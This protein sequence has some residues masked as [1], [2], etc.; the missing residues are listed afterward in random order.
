MVGMTFGR[1]FGGWFVTKGRKL[2]LYTS[3]VI[4]LL[5]IGIMMV[6]DIR[7]FIVGRFIMGL[8]VGIFNSVGVRFVEEC[9]PP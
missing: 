1:L 7:F 4:D 3:A 2:S 8:G 5:A 6:E 9:S